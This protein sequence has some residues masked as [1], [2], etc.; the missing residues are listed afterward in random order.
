[1]LLDD[2]TPESDVRAGHAIGIAALP[3]RVIS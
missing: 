3:E 2:W 1:M